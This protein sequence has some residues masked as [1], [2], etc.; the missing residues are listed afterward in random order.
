MVWLSCPGFGLQSSNPK[1]NN[2]TKPNE[3]KTNIYL[4]N[5]IWVHEVFRVP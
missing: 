1:Q 3:Q 2:N 5:A 4:S